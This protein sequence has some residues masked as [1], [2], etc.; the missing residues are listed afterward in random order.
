MSTNYWPELRPETAARI[1]ASIRRG[2][3][4][5]AIKLYREANAVG[6]KEA[7]DAIDRANDLL[8]DQTAPIKRAQRSDSLTK[9]ILIAIIVGAVLLLL[10]VFLIR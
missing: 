3:K 1:E 4:I 6:L 7:K 5:E 8:P 10:V 9:K 2:D